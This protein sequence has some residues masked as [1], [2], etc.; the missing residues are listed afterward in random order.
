MSA[1]HMEKKVFISVTSLPIGKL[2]A[3]GFR[4]PEPMRALKLQ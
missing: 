3:G 4:D 1:R 2:R